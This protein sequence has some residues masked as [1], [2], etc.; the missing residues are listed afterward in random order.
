[1]EEKWMMS[2]ETPVFE[3]GN[4]TISIGDSI[5]DDSNIPCYKITNKDTKVVEAET[6][7]LPTAIGYAKEFSEGL[8]KVMTNND[9]PKVEFAH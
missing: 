7:V 4:Y 5:H 8:D 2:N 9:A 6:T 1:M 3:N